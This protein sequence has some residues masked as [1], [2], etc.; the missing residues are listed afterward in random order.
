MRIRSFLTVR[1]GLL[2]RNTSGG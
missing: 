2:A 1:E